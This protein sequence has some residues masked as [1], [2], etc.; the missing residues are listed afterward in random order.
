VPF[1][2]FVVQSFFIYEKANKMDRKE[3][4][5]QDGG[6]RIGWAIE[7]ITPEGPAILFGQYYDRKSAYVHSPLKATACA[8]ESVDRNGKREQAIMLSLDLLWVSRD[9]QNLLKHAVAE[10]IPDFDVRK[11][12]VNAIHTHSAPDPD[13]SLD[14][15]KFVAGK[16]C[17]A[18]IS[19]WNNRKPAG[20]SRGLGYAVTGHCRRVRYADGSAEMYGAT[21]RDDFIGMEGSANP[22]V[23][24]LFCW[25]LKK[26]L[27]GIIMNVSCPAQVTE[28]KYYV[29]SDYW[30]EVRKYLAA[31]FS[32]EV[33]V[34]P[35]TGASGDLSPRDLPR[36]YKSGEPNMWDIP[37][38]EEI[39][40]RLANTF[41]TV[42]RE[43]DT[44]ID[45]RPVFRHEV[46][47][48]DL[49]V[50]RVSDAE[51]H[52]ALEIVTEIRS[53]EPH[54]PDSPD[55]A[56]NR[57]LKE[58]EENEKTREYGPW[59]DK[60]SDFGVLKINEVLLN[61]YVKQ[62]ENPQ[63]RMELHVLR[64]GEVAFATNPFELYA[65]Y[66]FRITGRSRAKQTF[67]IQLC[68]DYGD[69]LPT[70]RGITGGQY[71]ALVS[72][73]GPVGGQAMVDETVKTIDDLWE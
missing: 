22:G 69:Y 24:M 38:A 15:G 13:P 50:R 53:R 5:L 49:P 4:L 10:K 7:D 9:M 17:D 11:L 37:G 68:G 64:I 70:Q 18:V 57:F 67:I 21:D 56:W 43:A 14:Y 63:Y 73:V 54:D 45:T 30:G 8:I 41:E 35:Q 33:F 29:S 72:R 42:Y 62:D 48:I 27:T 12:F 26:E 59:D 31:K 32:H 39:G 52:K 34:L 51:Y 60:E 65:D 28:A 2:L 3:T 66:G 55:T 40:K 47:D 6:L 58:I 16:M 25:N 1:V 20:I 19:A 44:H 46:R 71:S 36:G 23:D 61:N